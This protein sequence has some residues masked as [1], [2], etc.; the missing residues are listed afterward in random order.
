M[1]P[2][3]GACDVG[4]VYRLRGADEEVRALAATALPQ[5]HAERRDGS[6]LA[7]LLLIPVLSKADP[8][9]RVWVQVIYRRGVFVINLLPVCADA[10]LKTYVL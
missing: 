5:G 4:I 8:E 6:G 1:F 3:L 7:D 2:S 10:P 9:T